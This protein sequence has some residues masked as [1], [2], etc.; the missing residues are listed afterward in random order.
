MTERNEIDKE[1]IKRR[2][3]FY[4]RGVRNAPTLLNSTVAGQ[5]CFHGNR[6]D[7]MAVSATCITLDLHTEAPVCSR[8]T[9]VIPKAFCI[10]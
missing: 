7:W 9:A 1:V 10:L 4:R 6:T 5:E 8:A 3:C 2:S